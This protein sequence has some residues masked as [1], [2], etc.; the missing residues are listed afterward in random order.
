MNEE[1]LVSNSPLA[2]NM[3]PKKSSTN[4][5]LISFTTSA[6]LTVLGLLLLILQ[7]DIFITLFALV[8]FIVG[9]VQVIVDLGW[10]SITKINLE[11]DSWKDAYPIVAGKRNMKIFLVPFF[12]DICFV[13][14]SLAL[15]TVYSM[16]LQ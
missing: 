3:E 9:M 15:F 16:N 4:F 7:V 10:I 14:V 1:K 13:F 11:L 2:S 5:F 8:V 12:F 6:I